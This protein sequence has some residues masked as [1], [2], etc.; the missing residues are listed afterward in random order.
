MKIS[1][2]FSIITLSFLCHSYVSAQV[3]ANARS[4]YFQVTLAGSIAYTDSVV[5][6]G[7][8]ADTILFYSIDLASR[9]KFHYLQKGPLVSDSTGKLLFDYRLTTGQKLYVTDGQY[10]DTFL[11]D[12]I[13]YIKMGQGSYKTWHLHLLGNLMFNFSWTQGFGSLTYGWNYLEYRIADKGNMRKA[14]CLNDSL[15]YWDTTFNGFEPNMPVPTC[16]YHELKHLLSNKD[17]NTSKGLKIYPVPASD[18]LT[19]ES[20]YPGTMTIFDLQGREVVHQAI[21]SGTQQLDLK[22]FPPGTY[23]LILNGERFT[24]SQNFIIS[25]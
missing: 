15:F 11:V 12:S 21:N 8:V 13:T 4:F 2:L 20:A 6:E 7:T 3:K 18:I 24:T 19:V 10:N 25:R 23:W 16:D 14:I 17:I 9:E 5:V 22:R 1:R